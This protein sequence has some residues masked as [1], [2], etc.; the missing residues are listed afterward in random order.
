MMGEIRD[1]FVEGT[2][3]AV[4]CSVKDYNQHFKLDYFDS[5]VEMLE[6]INDQQ[7]KIMQL[8]RINKI[9]SD[10]LEEN[11]IDSSIWVKEVF[12]DE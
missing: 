8:V 4:E 9:L 2:L 7:E 1:K 6:V 11:G 3:K 12:S 10:R 5:E